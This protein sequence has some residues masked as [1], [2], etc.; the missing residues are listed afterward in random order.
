MSGLVRR[1][2]RQGSRKGFV[3]GWK[4]RPRSDNESA[5][6][7]RRGPWR[8]A[9]LQG[10]G[11]PVSER[12]G[13]AWRG[14]GSADTG[15]ARI[16]HRCGGVRCSSCEPRGDMW[17]EWPAV[18]GVRRTGWRIR[19]AR[20]AA[21][22]PGPLSGCGCRRQ[23]VVEMGSAWAWALHDTKGSG[24]GSGPDPGFRQPGAC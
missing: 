23:D 8:V 9:G 5:P 11:R 20:C 24:L 3:G 6:T 10:A 18:K 15:Q 19:G 2:G 4:R 13:V 21:R 22:R 14:P 1:F 7:W 12:T 16:P 17:A